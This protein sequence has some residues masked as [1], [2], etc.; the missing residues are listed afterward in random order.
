[1]KNKYNFL[2][3]LFVLCYG[4]G[5][6]AACT[7]KLKIRP[8]FGG[9]T[10]SFDSSIPNNGVL[11]HFVIE[12]EEK[13]VC[14]A[15]QAASN[16]QLFAQLVINLSTTFCEAVP[17]GGTIFGSNIPGVVW[18]FPKGYGCSHYNEVPL[19]NRKNADSNRKVTWNVGELQ[20]D[21]KLRLDNRFDFRNSNSFTVNSIGATGGL[22]GDRSITIPLS[23]SSFTYNY[24]N[25]A[26]CSL[27]APSE[28]NF[29][30]VT[31]SDVLNGTTHRDLNLRA[32]CR[33]RG[34]SLGLNFKFEPQHKDASANMQGVFYAKNSTGSLAY[35]L[36]KKS[37]SAAIPLNEF[38]KLVNEDNVNIH[39]GNTIQLSLSLQKGDGLIA[40]GIV[41]TFLNVTMEHM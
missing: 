29:N 10:Y 28:V 14:D 37:D 4:D 30:T 22:S 39:S 20:Y 12:I 3:F 36:M 13:I 38:I 18:Y 6:L 27:T 2:L 32:E 24:T 25:I 34:A 40:T 16:N 1:M 9:H 15:N 7:G 35:K 17:S 41:E 8:V 23:G 11:A 31:T 5:V 21:L 33:N 26:T 19:G